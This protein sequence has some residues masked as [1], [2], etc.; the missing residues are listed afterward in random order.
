MTTA[1]DPLPLLPT[2]VVGSHARPAWWWCANEAIQQGRFGERDVAETLDHAVDIAILDQERLGIDVISD[3]E[4]RR[5]SGY[6]RTL[7]QRIEGLS[8]VPATARRWGPPHYDMDTDMQVDGPVSAPDGLGVARDFAYLKAHATHRTK[9]TCPGPLTFAGFCHLA[10]PYGDVWALAHAVAKLVNAELKA[11]VAAGA[12]FVQIDD[13]SLGIIPG[14]GRGM[15]E[16]VNAAFDGVQ[17]KRALHIC[18]GTNRGRPRGYNRTYRPLFPDLMEAQVD[19]FVFEFTNSPSLWPTGRMAV[20]STRKRC[21]RPSRTPPAASSRTAPM[22]PTSPS[23][24]RWSPMVAALRPAR[25]SAANRSRLAT[26]ASE[27]PASGVVVRRS[28]SACRLAM[29][30]SSSRPFAANSLAASEP[31]GASSCSSRIRLRR[32]RLWAISRSSAAPCSARRACP[33]A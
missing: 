6:V 10:P 2:T 31:A 3:G 22:S 15:V 26:C 24:A 8:A 16:L 12:E 21:L 14:E 11:C 1:A 18:F 28:R 25:T 23:T 13:P 17:A 27:R 20:Q 5:L 19:Q 9:A 33:C 30:A 4:M 32:A 29:R 7:L